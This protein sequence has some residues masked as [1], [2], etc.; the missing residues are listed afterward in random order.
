MQQAKPISQNN[1][2]IG[3]A[4]LNI[5][6]YNMRSSNILTTLAF[7]WNYLFV[8]CFF[9]SFFVWIAVV[10]LWMFKEHERFVITEVR[11]RSCSSSCPLGR[12]LQNIL[13]VILRVTRSNKI[14]LHQAP[15]LA[16]GL[17]TGHDVNLRKIGLRISLYRASLFFVYF[18]QRE[19]CSAWERERERK[20]ERE[21]VCVCVLARE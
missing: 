3:L 11:R 6:I 8:Q 16:G 9:L 2:R 7:P 12:P 1:L 14:G 4:Y 10:A 13:F 18:A 19:S 5:Y 20:R 15:V 21:S 17:R